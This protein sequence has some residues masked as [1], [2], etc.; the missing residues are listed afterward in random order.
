M[1]EETLTEIRDWK[2]SKVKQ[3]SLFIEGVKVAF[4]LMG[5]IVVLF[6]LVFS[7]EIIDSFVH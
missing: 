4:C 1:R 5:I 6:C 7:K 3:P 2:D